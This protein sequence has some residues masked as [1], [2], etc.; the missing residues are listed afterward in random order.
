MELSGPAVGLATCFA[1]KCNRRLSPPVPRSATAEGQTLPTNLNLDHDRE[2][3]PSR[4]EEENRLPAHRISAGFKTDFAGG[5]CHWPS[6]PGARAFLRV[7]TAASPLSAETARARGSPSGEEGEPGEGAPFSQSISRA[8][9]CPSRTLDLWY[10]LPARLRFFNDL[11]ALV[12]TRPL[13]PL[14]RPD[15]G[16]QDDRAHDCDDD[17][18]DQP[19]G[20]GPEQAA[21]QGA[22]QVSSAR[23]LLPLPSLRTWIR[24]QTP[25]PRSATVAPHRSY[26]VPD[27]DPAAS[28]RKNA[29]TGLRSTSGTTITQMTQVGGQCIGRVITALRR[30]RR[31]ER[32]G[33]SHDDLLFLPQ[34]LAAVRQLA[35]CGHRSHRTSHPLVRPG[36]FLSYRIWSTAT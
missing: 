2:A 7:W 30:R 12:V 32:K 25:A 24:T 19:H 1:T 18:A 3:G 6:R 9:K 17:R 33:I 22:V 26:H 21:D 27:H 15:D 36:Q 4:R 20:D 28:A 8:W 14:E 5:R 29:I 23:L 11:H 35:C 13:R 34:I 16:D 10:H 31:T